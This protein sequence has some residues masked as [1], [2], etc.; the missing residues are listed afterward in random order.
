M[1]VEAVAQIQEERALFSGKAVETQLLWSLM[2]QQF[3]D[4]RI[5]EGSDTTSVEISS[6]DGLMAHRKAAIALVIGDGSPT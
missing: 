1:P 4:G 2:D 5:R 3:H 6:A